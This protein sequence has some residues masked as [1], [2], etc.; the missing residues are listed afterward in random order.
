MIAQGSGPTRSIPTCQRWGMAQVKKRSIAL[1][2]CCS[3]VASP[4][5]AK[6][7][8]GVLYP[9]LGPM[10]AIGLVELASEL[11][12]MPDVEVATYLHQSWKALVDDIN[13]QPKGTH[14][15]IVGYSLGA[16]NAILVANNTGYVDSIIALQPSMLT[17]QDSLTGKVGKIIEIYNPN[18][19]MT[20]G[21]MGSQKLEAPNI[22]Y[23]VNN[24]THPGAQ[25]NAQ[26]HTVVKNE[27]ARLVALDSL[28]TAQA[29]PTKP[30]LLAKLAPPKESKSS[31]LA[32]ANEEASKRDQTKHEQIRHDQAKHEQKA[33]PVFADAPKPQTVFADAPKPQPI[34]AE[35]LSSSVTADNSFVQRTLTIG[36][37][38][39]YVKR[40]YPTAQTV[41]LTR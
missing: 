13:R 3:L 16:N 6:T 24:D 21:G 15:L 28:Q 11:K 40:N 10:A 4:V 25:F 27:L 41:G 9:F 14:I 31:Q 29:K 23:I 17:T 35:A 32:F 7:F 18:P 2:L 1:A 20:F 34:F 8:V 39:E 12:A 38:K 37:M 33:Q 22:E 30:S 36:D 26:F 5:W 19:W